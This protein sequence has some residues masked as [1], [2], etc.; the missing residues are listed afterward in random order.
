MFEEIDKNK[1]NKIK[2]NKEN[3]LSSPKIIKNDDIEN[4][5]IVLTIEERIDEGELILDGIKFKGIE[6][7]MIGRWIE[8]D[9]YGGYFQKGGSRQPCKYQAM[10]FAG[11]KL[12][13]R[14]LKP[15][16]VMA[17]YLHGCREPPFWK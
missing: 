2:T 7:S 14:R 3:N 5:R 16:K 6:D 12:L 8:S 13:Y 4:D 10:T 15:A 11:F 17:W 9:S 1:K